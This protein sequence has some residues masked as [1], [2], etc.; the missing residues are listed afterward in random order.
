MA[1]SYPPTTL[2]VTDN[3]I[4]WTDLWFNGRFEDFTQ[5]EVRDILLHRKSSKGVSYTDIENISRSS[6]SKIVDS[7]WE[8]IFELLP[9]DIKA[10]NK[11]W[12]IFMWLQQVCR[13]QHTYTYKWIDCCFV[14]ELVLW[15]FNSY[16]NGWQIN[17]DKF[18]ITYI[19]QKHKD[20]INLEV[21]DGLLLAAWCQ[22]DTS[23]INK[24]TLEVEDPD[25]RYRRFH[26]AVHLWNG[27]YISKYWKKHKFCI[28]TLEDMERNYQNFWVFILQQ[29]PDTVSEYSQG[30]WPEECY[31]DRWKRKMR[32]KDRISW[33]RD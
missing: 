26:Y 8:V 9:E 23:K 5:V 1:N 21:W 2:E 29:K 14:F 25:F 12:Q 13:L 24:D 4:P 3:L 11:K 30:F 33:V 16:H 27:Y 15:V 28:G 6:P 7:N 17:K 32:Q 31:M 19:L 20:Q 18:N 10:Q 22:I